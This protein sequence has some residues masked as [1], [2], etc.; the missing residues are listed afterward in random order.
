MLGLFLKKKKKEKKVTQIL[1]SNKCCDVNYDSYPRHRIRM[2]TIVIIMWCSFRATIALCVENR[3]VSSRYRRGKTKEGKPTQ[4]GKGTENFNL[5]CYALDFLWN[6]RNLNHQIIMLLFLRPY[7][8]GFEP[9]SIMVEGTPPLVTEVKGR[10]GR[11]RTFQF[12]YRFSR[13]WCSVFAM[14]PHCLLLC[15]HCVLVISRFL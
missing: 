12:K 13:I 11:G 8:P 14:V 3:H 6:G 2:R 10:E 9:G 1:E 4:T 7:S 5:F 15:I